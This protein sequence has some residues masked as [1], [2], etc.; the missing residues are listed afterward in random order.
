[1]KGL[2]YPPAL[3]WVTQV[4]APDLRENLNLLFES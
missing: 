3:F 4:N 1:M 2:V